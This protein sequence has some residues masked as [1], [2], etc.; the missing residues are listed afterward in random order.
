M[1]LLFHDSLLISLMGTW[2]NPVYTHNCNGEPFCSS[3]LELQNG[4][5][6]STGLLSHF[7]LYFLTFLRRIQ[8]TAPGLNSVKDHA[9][10]SRLLLQAR[11]H[12]LLDVRCRRWEGRRLG[13]ITWRVSTAMESPNSPLATASYQNL[14]KPII[15]VEIIS[16][17]L[18]IV[19]MHLAT[20]CTSISHNNSVYKSP[21]LVF[22]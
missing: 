9:R 12:A 22:W 7:R 14:P 13:P 4:L 8:A 5:S 11:T 18:I 21:S 10:Y 15:V 6:L 1:W 16:T 3:N 19:L 17:C 20:K 2:A